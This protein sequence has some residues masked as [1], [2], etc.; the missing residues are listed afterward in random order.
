MELLLHSPSS[1]RYSTLRAKTGKMDEPV[2]GELEAEILHDLVPNEIQT[3]LHIIQ[4]QS[5]AA[6]IV[7]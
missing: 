7:F 3:N 4:F 2:N 6:P 1:R 5:S